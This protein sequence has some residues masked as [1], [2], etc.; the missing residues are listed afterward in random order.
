MSFIRMQTDMLKKKII[1]LG[2]DNVKE[3]KISDIVFE[4]T[5]IELCEMNQCGNYGKCYTCPPLIGDMKT[6]IEKAKSYSHAIVFQKIYKIEDSF[7]FE[8]MENASK[9]FS[10]LVQTV[11]EIRTTDTLLL[12]AGGCRLCKRCGAIDGVKCRFPNK[13]IPSLESYGINVSKLSEKSGM[14]Y[15][16]GQNT[17]TYFGSIFIREKKYGI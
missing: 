12:G 15:I 16:N 2:F 8:G 13:A 5:L 3:I 1:S 10:C 14:N 4:P 11:N 6:L 9:E 17:V 7:D